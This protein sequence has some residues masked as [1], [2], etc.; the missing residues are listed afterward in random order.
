MKSRCF[1]MEKCECEK[2][3]SGKRR[4]PYLMEVYRAKRK[5]AHVTLNGIKIILFKRIII[6]NN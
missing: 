3:S 4:K 5:L 1:G 6:S 2:K